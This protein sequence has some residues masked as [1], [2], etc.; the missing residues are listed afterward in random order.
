MTPYFSAGRREAVDGLVEE[1]LRGVDVSVRVGAEHGRGAEERRVRD[2][3]VLC[4]A[5]LGDGEVRV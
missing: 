5:R 4:G 3:E 2:P 1:P